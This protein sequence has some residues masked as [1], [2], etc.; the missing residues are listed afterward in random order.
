MGP[1]DLEAAAEAARRSAA[2][3]LRGPSRVFSDA[4]DADGI[5]ARGLGPKVWAGLSVRQRDRLRTHVRKTFESALA[6]RGSAP[7]EISW[8]FSEGR[9]DSVRVTL[10]VRYGSANLKTAWT[11]IPAAKGWRIADVTISDPGISLAG[12]AMAALGSPPARAGDAARAARREA[13]PR[14]FGLFAI[15][16]VV[17][18][19][20]PRLKRSGDA[21]AGSPSASRIDS[22]RVLL[23]MTAAAPAFLFLADGV[24]AV[25]RA[26]SEP[27]SLSDTPDY[28][29]REAAE[30]RALEAERSG[31]PEEAEVLSREAVRLGAPGAALAFQRGLEAKALGNLAAAR[32]AFETALAADRPAPGAA[33]ELAL[34]E[35]SS[36]RA[37][38]ARDL[39]ERYLRETGPDPDALAALAV[40]RSNA[41]DRGGAVGAMREARGL[42][43]QGA[44]RLELEARVSARAGD[45]PATV[46]ALRSVELSRPLDRRALRS[47]P[48]FL[49]IAVEPAWVRFLAERT[50]GPAPTAPVPGRLPGAVSPARTPPP[51]GPAPTVPGKRR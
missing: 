51:A 33:R 28:E 1:P 5:L 6:P 22:R 12:R 20:W 49:P 30:R 4:L 29:A 42:L 38:E 8:V 37:Q 2:A 41:G 50:P 16:L 17:V 32:R 36:G 21:A 40:A 7:G 10:G 14:L 11:M 3:A 44:A 46:A 18:L 24:L 35:L 13:L 34:M 9:P 39:L 45:A 25:R 23:L 26:L 31:R 48:A 19:V 43:P 15:A 47:D 27:Y